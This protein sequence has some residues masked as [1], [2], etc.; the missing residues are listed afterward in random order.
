MKFQVAVATISTT[1]GLS[2]FAV[3][4]KEEKLV[5]TTIVEKFVPAELGQRKLRDFGPFDGTAE[6]PAKG[7]SGSSLSS[8]KETGKWSSTNNAKEETLSFDI[9]ILESNG[10]HLEGDNRL[11]QFETDDV[12]INDLMDIYDPDE[13][14]DA[15][16]KHSME[17]TCHLID[18]MNGYAEQYGMGPFCDSCGS[19][20]VPNAPTEAYS[21]VLNCPYL[22]SLAFGSGFELPDELKG[23]ADDQGQAY[24]QDEAFCPNCPAVCQSCNWDVTSNLFMSFE[25]C[26]ITS[27]EQRAGIEKFRLVN[28][29]PLQAGATTSVSSASMLTFALAGASILAMVM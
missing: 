18:V 19:Y 3:D 13:L 29:L 15:P 25:N 4:A 24:C 7:I 8:E 21:V 14:Y 1:V 28:T 12:L 17:L 9:G 26:S 10:E 20:P 22:A 5:S 2:A 23:M 6:S 27:D 11:L 16:L